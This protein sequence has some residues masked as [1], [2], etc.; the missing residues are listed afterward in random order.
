MGLR[1]L[2]A[3]ELREGVREPHEDQ[4]RALGGSH[5]QIVVLG[6]H[7]IE[8]AVAQPERQPRLELWRRSRRAHFRR[9]CAR[10]EDG[11]GQQSHDNRQTERIAQIAG[12]QRQARPVL[13]GETHHRP[14]PESTERRQ[15]QGDRGP[16]QPGP[17]R[18]PGDPLAGQHAGGDQ[19]AGSDADE[20][21]EGHARPEGRRGAAEGA[22]EAQEGGHRDREAERPPGVSCPRSANGRGSRLAHMS[23]LLAQTLLK[24]PATRPIPQRRCTNALGGR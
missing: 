10:A 13:E 9:R 20:H 14:H 15:D 23:R 17:R 8:L 12:Q 24:P 7:R 18:Q 5:T 19:H 21:E 11:P 1:A 22:D 16:P 4:V 6:L 2:E 3:A